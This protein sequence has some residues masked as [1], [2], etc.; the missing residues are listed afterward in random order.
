M[1]QSNVEY[2]HREEVVCLNKEELE[3]ILLK[4][5]FSVL[6]LDCRP[7]IDFKKNTILTSIH[8]NMENVDLRDFNLEDIFVNYYDKLFF[9]QR[10]FV[11]VVIFD[12]SLS[13]NSIKVYQ[14]L[15]IENKTKEL[16]ILEDGFKDF[17]KLNPLLC[18]KTMQTEKNF[19][20]Y[21]SVEERAKIAHSLLFKSIGRKPKYSETPSQILPFLYLGNGLDFYF[22]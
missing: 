17:S 22:F 6:L 10:E 13:E 7:S 20:I 8:V 19:E 18:S 16:Y 5:P 14:M 9:R 15:Q 21:Y 11:K 2:N 4:E 12:E 1:V 3:K